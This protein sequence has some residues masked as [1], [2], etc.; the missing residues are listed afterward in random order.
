MESK[1]SYST[2]PNKMNEIEHAKKVVEMVMG[3][4][5]ITK[6]RKRDEVEGRMVLAS[7]LREMGHSLKQIGGV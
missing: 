5:V 2:D 6:H 1:Q 3:I 7:I 4:D